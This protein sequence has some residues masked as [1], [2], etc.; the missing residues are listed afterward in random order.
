[1]PFSS[2]A[3]NAQIDDS[4]SAIAL[5]NGSCQAVVEVEI[6]QVASSWYDVL[7]QELGAAETL[8]LGWRRSGVLYFD[9]D[10][11][12]AITTYGTSFADAR[13]AIDALFASLGNDFTA[14][15][16]A[17]LVGMLQA[18]EPPLDTMASSIASYLAKLA[19][20]EE[21]MLGV[22]DRMTTTVA[23]VQAQEADVQAQIT[24]INAQIAS[25]TAQVATD[26]QAIAKARSARTDGILETI[27][28]VLLAPLTGG[29]SLVLAGFG[30]VSIAEAQ[31]D[32]DALQAS[33]EGY[34]ST[35]ASD[36]ATLTDDQRTVV[37]LTG[38][39]SSTQFVLDDIAGIGTS[40]DALRVTWTTFHGELGDIVTKLQDATTAAELVVAQAWYDA[41][42]AEWAIVVEHAGSL[43]GLPVTTTRVQVG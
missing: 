19:T 8:V 32:V 23:Q 10:V 6:Q 21:S 12:G 25:L 17:Q 4:L 37:T 39:T 22:Q 20:F 43:T 24:A 14:A 40:L 33:I 28:G 35:I 15:G 7:D 18:L 16:Q 31:S 41:A 27:F 13:P 30:A 42:C 5:L 11:L 36:Q 34:Q 3:T 38:L 2:A 26:R 29:A 9:G 1:M